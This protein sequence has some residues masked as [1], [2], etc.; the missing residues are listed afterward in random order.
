MVGKKEDPVGMTVS[1]YD[2]DAIQK[3][4]TKAKS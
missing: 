4:V 1:E 3:G 2:S